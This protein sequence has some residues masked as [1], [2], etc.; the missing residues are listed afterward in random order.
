MLMLRLASPT[1][2]LRTRAM[3]SLRSGLIGYHESREWVWAHGQKYDFKKKTK[4]LPWYFRS[5][6]NAPQS[7]YIHLCLRSFSEQWD[8]HS[9][10]SMHIHSHHVLWAR[11]PMDV[12]VNYIP[13]V[14][15]FTKMRTKIISTDSY[16]DTHIHT[17]DDS[18][19]ARKNMEMVFGALNEHS[20]YRQKDA[21]AQLYNGKYV[22]C[23]V[24]ASIY[25]AIHLLYI[26]ITSTN[27]MQSWS[28]VPQQPCHIFGC[29]YVAKGS[30][31][32]DVSSALPPKE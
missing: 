7:K 30:H 28:P 18:H 14:S 15:W 23:N 21:R 29:G 1:I 27:S 16:I 25:V 17:E 22:S 8:R 32:L 31:P 12:S 26:Q 11:T 19:T 24:S 10:A 20:G 2:M 9:D 4:S 13:H 3:R 5:A 6:Q